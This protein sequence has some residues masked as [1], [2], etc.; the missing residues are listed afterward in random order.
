M[1]QNQ[2]QTN[3]NISH[4]HNHNSGNNNT[5]QVQPNI[6][7]TPK[8][9][10]SMKCLLEILIKLEKINTFKSQF[11]ELISSAQINKNITFINSF[12]EIFNLLNR[13]E[14]STISK[15]IY[16]Q[17]INNFIRKV[18]LENDS[19]INGTRPIMLYYMI[20]KIFINEFSRYF[21]NIYKNKI[22]DELIE[23]NYSPLNTIIPVNDQTIYN[24]LNKT[25]ME[26]KDNYKGPF[27]DNFYFLSMSSSRCPEC[28][29]LFGIRYQVNSFLQLTVPHQQNNITQL[30][31]NYFSSYSETGA[32]YNCICGSKGKNK[33]KKFCLNLP[34]YLVLELEDNNSIIFDDT[35]SVPLY[36]QETFSYQYFA[37]IYKY[38][39][40]NVSNFVAVIKNGNNFNFY[41]D[42]IIE[43]CPQNYRNL[44]RPSMVIYKKIS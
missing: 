30:I 35:I 23:N 5:N 21:N 10:S 19:E 17:K 9:V 37:G 43:P 24:S 41:H 14:T 34:N 18:F 38:I 42:D 28:N 6:E 1:S 25:I 2:T 40:N 27:V 12:Y 36:N 22:F 44:E 20:S 7:I 39:N 13:F 31:N 16:I 29:R 11:Y 26:F 15:E 3:D 33:K 32:K 8:L 4:N